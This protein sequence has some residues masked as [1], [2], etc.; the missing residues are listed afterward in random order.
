MIKNFFDLTGRVAVVVGG[1]SGLGRTIA[2]GLAE[3]GAS[4]VAT[5]RRPEVTE[6]VSAAIR[7]SGSRDSQPSCGCDKAGR[8]R[9]IAGCSPEAVR[10]G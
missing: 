1:T 5:G 4:V 6:E 2:M 3:A 9:W 8:D 7:A 10:P